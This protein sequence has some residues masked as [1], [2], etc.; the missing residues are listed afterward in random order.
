MVEF[1]RRLSEDEFLLELIDPAVARQS[2]NLSFPC[3]HYTPQSMVSQ[4]LKALANR[5]HPQSRDVFDLYVLW[6]GGHLD[7]SIENSL[8]AVELLAA[9][10]NLFS[11][12]YLD[13]QGQVLEFLEPEQREDYEGEVMWNSVCEK[14]LSMLTAG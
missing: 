14:V 11:F 8:S 4:K 10:E 12:T 9:E 1:S 7:L 13:Y 2:R 3:Q 5:A 6:L